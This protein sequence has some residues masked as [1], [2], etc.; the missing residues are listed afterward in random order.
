MTGARDTDWV[1]A[2][3]S[4]VCWICNRWVEAR[5]TWTPHVSGP[6]PGAG[7]TVT[8]HLS[9]D[10]YRAEEMRPVLGPDGDVAWY[11]LYRV[12]PPSLGAVR[13]Y[14]SVEGVRCTAQDAPR[15]G[16]PGTEFEVR[17]ACVRVCL[18]AC[19]SV[20]VSVLVRLCVCVCVCVCVFV[21]VCVCLCVCV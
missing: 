2:S 1:A 21:C 3:S 17:A 6:G 18:C 16:E 20:R 7:G 8:C 11:E 5:L 13:Y 15:D 14:F 9:L 19:V 4:G 10:G 12:V